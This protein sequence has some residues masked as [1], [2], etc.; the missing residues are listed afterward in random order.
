M[1]NTIEFIDLLA[2]LKAYKGKGLQRVG[3]YGRITKKLPRPVNLQD[4]LIES[5]NGI[6]VE[7]E[8]FAVNL[9]YYEAYLRSNGYYNKDS[10]YMVNGSIITFV[11]NT[12]K[13]EMEE[14]VA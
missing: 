7:M 3:A 13:R 10:I 11:E 8:L 12:T 5:P 14:A 9:K 1:Q 6:F 4:S 2:L